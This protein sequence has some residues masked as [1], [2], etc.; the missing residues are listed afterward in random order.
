MG[1]HPISTVDEL[2]HMNGT[3]GFSKLVDM[4]P[5]GTSAVKGHARSPPL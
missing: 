3:K 5:A 4:P 2:L 1:Q